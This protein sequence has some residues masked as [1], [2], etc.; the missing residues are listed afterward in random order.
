MQIV[1]R[2]FRWFAQS[3]IRCSVCVFIKTRIHYCTYLPRI[4][5]KVMD[6]S[7]RNVRQAIRGPWGDIDLR[8]PLDV[9]ANEMLSARE[10][11]Y[12]RKILVSNRGLGPVTGP[13]RRDEPTNVEERN[14]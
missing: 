14:P 1:T 13:D 9:T 12:D 11:C 3:R 6:A 7:G 5:A 10:R 2:V 4:P 8:E